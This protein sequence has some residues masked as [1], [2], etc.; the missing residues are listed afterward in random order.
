MFGQ[1]AETV[2][3]QE[4][5]HDVLRDLKAFALMN[6]LP[7]FA[8]KIAEAEAVLAAELSSRGDGGGQ[9]AAGPH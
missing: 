4:W 5:I 7:A 1:K 9:G 8:Q 6:E 3:R 2:M